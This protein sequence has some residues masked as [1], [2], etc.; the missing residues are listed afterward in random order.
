MVSAGLASYPEMI[1]WKPK[2]KIHLFPFVDFPR[3]HRTWLARVLVCGTPAFGQLSGQY[4][5][6]SQAAANQRHFS[7]FA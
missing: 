3:H 2:T 1:K 6:S 5:L 7:L 4:L